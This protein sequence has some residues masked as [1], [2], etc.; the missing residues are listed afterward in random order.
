MRQH[1]QSK[2][3]ESSE[4]ESCWRSEKKKKKKGGR[5]QK[6]QL[7]KCFINLLQFCHSLGKEEKER[8]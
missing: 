3:R 8:E 4:K 5:T 2:L 1:A 7:G 6:K